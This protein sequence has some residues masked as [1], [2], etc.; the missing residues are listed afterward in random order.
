MIKAIVTDVDGVIIGT[1]KSK[2][3]PYPDP[4]IKSRFK[5]IR[6]QIPIILCS[7]KPSFGLVHVI[8]SLSLNN[9]HIATNG[10]VILN[11]YTAEFIVEKIPTDLSKTILEKLFKNNINADFVGKINFFH[12]KDKVTPFIKYLGE[13]RF[14]EPILVDDL[15]KTMDN[16]EVVRIDTFVDKENRSKVEEIIKP[17]LQY[18][19]LNW[20][21][22]PFDQIHIGLITIKGISKA[23]AVK[24]VAK[25]LNIPLNDFLGIGDTMNDWSFM[26]MCGQVG[27]MGNA[28][29][30]LLHVTESFDKDKII[31]K[32]VDENGLIDILNYY[33]L[34]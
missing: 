25:K 4:L 8:K 11:P 28:D 20:T 2:Y 31:A 22:A 14:S 33:Q 23:S 15:I 16:N 7:G 29:K 27:V 18:V 6:E 19:E 3:F 17:Y 21:T 24:K 32:H 13:I 9:L 10:A 12:L 34:V 1:K 5:K 26:Q 30:N